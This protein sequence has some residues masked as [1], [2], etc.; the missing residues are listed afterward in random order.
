M[1]KGRAEN[2]ATATF[3]RRSNEFQVKCSNNSIYS[4]DPVY[5]FIG[6]GCSV[7]VKIVRCIGARTADKLVFVTAVASFSDSHFINTAVH[8]KDDAKDAKTFFETVGVPPKSPITHSKERE[9]EELLA[10]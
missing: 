7:P 1:Q 10:V 2:Q 8:A 5:S 4:V 6:P 9:Q 3:S